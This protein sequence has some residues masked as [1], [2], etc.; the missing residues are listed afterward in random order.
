MANRNFQFFPIFK[1]RLKK[2]LKI[3]D[4]RGLSPGEY[5]KQFP[6]GLINFVKRIFSLTFYFLLGIIFCLSIFKV[7][8]LI[9]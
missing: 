4:E 6:R 9:K 7:A 1:K 8:K 5:R 2:G 3:K